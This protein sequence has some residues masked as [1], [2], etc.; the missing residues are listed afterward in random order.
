MET[1]IANSA[2]ILLGKQGE[3]DARKIQFDISRLVG[4]FGAGTVQLLHRRPGDETPYPVPITRAGAMVTWTVSSADTASAGTGQA[5]LQYFVGNTLAKSE[6]YYTIITAS[7]GAAGS[8]PPEPQAGWV[9]QVLQAGIDATEAAARAENAALH[10]PIIGDNGNWWLWDFDLGDYVDSGLPSAGEGTGANAPVQSVNGETGDVILSAADV[11]ARPDTW[12]PTSE[13][14][15]ARP[16]TWTPTAAETGADPSGTATETVAA[17][18]VDTEAHNDIRLA[19]EGLAT[20]LNALANSDDTTLDQMAEVVEYIKANRTLIESITT[21]KVSVSD[22]IDNLTTNI[23][24]QPL[25]AAQGVALKTLIDDLSSNKLDATAIADWAKAST[26]P[27]YTKSEVGLGNVENVKQYSASNPPPYPVTSVNE[28][29]GAVSLGAADVGAVATSD[30]V[31]G[32]GDSTTAVMSQAAVTEKLTTISNEKVDQNQ[33]SANVGKILVVGADGNLTLTD[34]PAGGVSGDVIGMIDENNNIILTGT[35]ADGTYVFKYES[36]DGTYA[37]IGS[38]V[39]GGK[40]EYA[41]T[42]SLTN[43]TG[44][45]SNATVIEEDGTAT[46]TFTA[47]DG[48]VL[49]ESVT[50]S[51]A[52]YTW[53][54]TTGALVLSAPTAD[55]AITITAIVY[56]AYTNVLPLAQQYASTAPYEGSDGSVGYG[57]NMRISTSSPTTTYMKAQDGV[58][59]TALIPVKRGDVLRLKNCNLKVTPSNTSYGTYIQGFDS[60]KAILTGFNA[61]YNNIF[62]RLPVVTDGDEIVQITI[63]PLEAWTTSDVDNLAYIMI[64]TDGLDETSIITINEEIVD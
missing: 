54:A 16:I 39:V 55:V 52:T 53:D 37:D 9:S 49:P 2:Q 50:V 32:T 14:V 3:N 48:Y 64:S 40:V 61:L 21:S 29:T 28:K 13:E 31:Q 1:I 4:L 26:K 45:S 63:E 41:I 59:A 18:N 57:N 51:G 58:D 60:S 56:V 25:S 22:I 35:L 44:A 6:T 62:I 43:C 20:R 47:N 19:I 38:L 17:H 10:P 34:M 15:G 30:I 11:G 23:S 46:L 5:E 8:T 12:T 42:A 27:A 36:A 7:L 33:G 24:D